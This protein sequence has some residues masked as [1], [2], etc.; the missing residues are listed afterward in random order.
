MPLGL[1]NEAAMTEKTKAADADNIQPPENNN[2]TATIIA[3]FPTPPKGLGV[4]SLSV[5]DC[6]SDNAKCVFRAWDITSDGT[7]LLQSFTILKSHK[8]EALA[9]LKSEL[10]QAGLDGLHVEVAP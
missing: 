7:E 4:I 10:A 1:E 6:D 5:S 3:H 8:D 2:N 9:R